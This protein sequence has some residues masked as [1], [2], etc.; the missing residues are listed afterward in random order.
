MNRQAAAPAQ[1]IAR[2]PQAALSPPRAAVP[3]STAVF[4]R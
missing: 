2:K 1:A 4:T 3:K